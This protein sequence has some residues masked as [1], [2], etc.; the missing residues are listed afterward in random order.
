MGKVQELAPSHTANKWQ[1]WRSNL[2]CQSRSKALP[3][4]EKALRLAGLGEA[5]PDLADWRR[6]RALGRFLGRWY[7]VPFCPGSS[8]QRPGSSVQPCLQLP[9][10]PGT[11][12]RSSTLQGPRLRMAGRGEP[13]GRSQSSLLAHSQLLCPGPFRGPGIRDFRPSKE[14]LYKMA[15]QTNTHKHTALLYRISLGPSSS[16]TRFCLHFTDKKP[17]LR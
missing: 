7:R 8:V 13:R 15:L 16:S 12:G 3:S 1:S 6:F 10:R 2:R 11:L 14:K 5:A 9:A 17:R 4:E